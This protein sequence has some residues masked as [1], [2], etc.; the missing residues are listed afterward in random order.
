MRSRSAND[1]PHLSATVAGTFTMAEDLTV[2]R[3]GYGAMQDAIDVVNLHVG[4]LT[5]PTPGSIAEPFT[6]S[7]YSTS[8]WLTRAEG[9]QC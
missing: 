1:S 2:T 3:M 7:S 9:P 5:N 6:L 8:P 4:G